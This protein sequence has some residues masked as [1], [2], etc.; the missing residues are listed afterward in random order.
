V[1]YKEY[2]EESIKEIN[3]ELR[4]I[5]NKALSEVFSQRY[6]MLISEKLKDHLI[7]KEVEYD[8]DNVVAYN[9]GTKIYINKNQFWRYDEKKQVRYL[10]H[11]FI[12][13]LQRKR[14]FVFSKFPEIR[15]LSKKLYTLVE[16]HSSQPVSVFL[17]GKN[18]DLGPGKKWEVPSY[19][20]NNSIDWRAIDEQGKALIIS[21][22]K[23]SGIF[24]TSSPFWKRRLPY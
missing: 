7:I 19:F 4:K 9:V 5:F 2:I 1:N 21:E 3:P 14:G 17:T 24:N 6:L 10:L 12:H 13:I 8:N 20:M 22:I 11:E 15:V 16:K 18:Q 23:N